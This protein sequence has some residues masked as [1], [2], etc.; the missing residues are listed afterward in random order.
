[1]IKEEEIKQLAALARIEI[2]EEEISKMQKDLENILDY[3]SELDQVTDDTVFE[4]TIGNVMRDDTQ[5]H[6]AGQ[7]TD[8]ILQAAPAIKGDLVN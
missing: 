1:M 5:F 6:P 4:S 2:P 8:D 7:Y 3:V